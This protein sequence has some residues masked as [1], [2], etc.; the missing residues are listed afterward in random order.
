VVFGW[1][2]VNWGNAAVYARTNFLDTLNKFVKPAP[3]FS[4]IM[5]HRSTYQSQHH[6]KTFFH[7]LDGTSWETLAGKSV[8]AIER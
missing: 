2:P 5:A 6:T 4:M 1:L 7:T 8:G 3:R